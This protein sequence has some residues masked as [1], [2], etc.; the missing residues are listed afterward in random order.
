MS[1]VSVSDRPDRCGKSSCAKGWT[2]VLSEAK[3]SGAMCGESG[4]P[5]PQVD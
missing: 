5:E 3:D 4:V 2:S 1:S